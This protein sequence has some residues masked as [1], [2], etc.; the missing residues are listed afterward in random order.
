MRNKIIKF[1]IISI[2]KQGDQ[3]K[4]IIFLLLLANIFSSS[5]FTN[6]NFELIQSSENIKLEFSLDDINFENINGYTKIVSSSMGETTIIGMPKL[7][8]FQI[9][10]MLEPTKNMVYH[11]KFYQVIY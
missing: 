5:L 2:L 7:P 1:D 3:L 6:E 9:M 4:K 11:I 8:T 10:I